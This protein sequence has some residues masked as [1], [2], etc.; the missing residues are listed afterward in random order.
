MTVLKADLATPEGAPT[1]LREKIVV[2]L[3]RHF[4][5]PDKIFEVFWER[6]LDEKLQ[7]K[8]WAEWAMLVVL[9]LC[10]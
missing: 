3:T 8:A 9:H 4:A 5:L 1:L 10:N 2:M 7:K 6:R